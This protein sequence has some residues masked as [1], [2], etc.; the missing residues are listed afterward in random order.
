MHVISFFTVHMGGWVVLVE[1]NCLSCLIR[2]GTDDPTSGNLVH[3]VGPN[4]G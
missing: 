2:N 1:K 4:M 3:L